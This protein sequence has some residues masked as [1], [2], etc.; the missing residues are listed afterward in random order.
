M[1]KNIRKMAWRNLWRNRRRS[2]ST[3]LAVATGFA[4]FMLAAGYAFR[5][6][7]VLSSHT[8]YA[9]HVGHIGIYK[10]DAIEKLS[11]NP[12]Q[13]SLNSDDQA[14]VAGAIQSVDHIEMSGRYLTGQGL[15]GNGCKSFPFVALGVDTS[16][17]QKV[18]TKPN[19]GKWTKHLAD[20]RVGSELWSFPEEMG[21]VAISQGL[22]QLLGK[23]KLHSEVA[24]V[25]PVL[26]QDCGAAGVRDLF[27][28]DANV[29]LAAGTWDGSLGVMDGEVVMR[30]STGLTETNNSSV[31]TSV[32]YLQAL[33][34]TDSITNFSIWLQDPSYLDQTIR[35]LRD[36]LRERGA[37]VEV[38]PWSDERLSPYYTGTMQ[39]IYVMVGFLGCVLSAVVILSIFNSA[40]MTVIERSQEVGMLRSLGYTQRWIR[41]MFALEG[42]FLTS[43]SVVCGAFFGVICMFGI[44]ALKITIHPPGVAGG[45]LLVFAPN[46]LIGLLGALSVGFLGVASTWLAVATVVRR[47]IADLVGGSLR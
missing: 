28:R 18:L 21:A 15:I 27:S 22:S 12:R 39:F 26:I 2:V 17:D 45:L 32:S 36:R 46:L 6:Q 14:M 1:Y 47:N 20:S 38:I 44:N 40:T 41:S 19:F 35:T 24:G 34:K 30:F 4:A 42:L 9:L 23:T 13:F 31:T 7:K 16:I 5:V 37:P 11:V 29:Q 33:L 25:K 10:K 3:G 43:I 8:I